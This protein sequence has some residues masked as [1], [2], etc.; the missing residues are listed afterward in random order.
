MARA[1]VFPSWGRRKHPRPDNRE[2]REDEALKRTRIATA[3][4]VVAVALTAADD[5]KTQTIEAR[6][7][8]IQ[9]PSTW[10]KVTP[11]SQM[12]AAQLRVEPTNGDAY[13][14]DLVV[15][16][17]PGGGGGVEQTLERW[18]KLFKDADGQAP[19]IETK[20]IQAKGGEVTRAETSG[21]Y[22]PSSG[23][24]FPADPAR[25]NAR[26]LG[27]ILLTDDAGYFIRMVGPDKTMK[28][29]APQFDEMIKSLELAK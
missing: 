29:L 10:K 17:F 13:P 21:D 24:G 1:S 26:L 14:A 4:A 3:L 15:F 23:P 5:P 7:L 19:K 11:A 22:Q 12:R 18:R 25:A 16:V 20:K 8:K 6:G 2:N 28:G 9:A 27:A